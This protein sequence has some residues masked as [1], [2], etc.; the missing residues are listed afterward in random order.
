MSERPLE[1]DADDAATSYQHALLSLHAHA[2]TYGDSKPTDVPGFA[3]RPPQDE[4]AVLAGASTADVSVSA[5]LD[6]LYRLARQ[7]AADDST[8]RQGYEQLAASVLPGRDLEL[9]QLLTDLRTSAQQGT[10]FAETASGGHFSHHETAFLGQQACTVRTVT[11]GGT[12]ATWIYSEIETD[13]DFRDLAAWVDPHKWSSWGPSFFKKMDFVGEPDPAALATPPGDDHWHGVFHEQVQLLRRLNTLL[14]C[15]YWRQSDRAVGMTYDLDLSL[16]GEIDVDRGYL[17]VTALEGGMKRVKALK[18]VGF[19]RPE[20]DALA[21]FVCPVWTDLVRQAVAGAT[22]STVTPPTQGPPSSS[23]LVDTFEAWVDFLGASAGTY[24]R[25]FESTSD[26]VRARSYSSADW[27]DDGRRYWSQL[28]KDW[29]RAWAHGMDTVNEV[30]EHGVD[31]GFTPPG[32]PH[33]VG[34]GAISALTTPATAEPPTAPPA[35]AGAAPG[36]TGAAPAAA[37][38]VPGAAAGAAPGAAPPA[39]TG[40]PPGG[41]GGQE[42]SFVPVPALTP[43]DAPTVSDLVSIEAGGA[44]LAATEITVTVHTEAGATPS[45]RLRTTNTTTPPGLY[46]G[47]LLGPAGVAGTSVQ[48]YVSRATEA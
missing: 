8:T 20:W 46:V 15:A 24:L 45:V 27:L 9:G 13:A 31:A 10:P 48:L 26:K 1:L 35:G 37:G 42:R 17:L 34:R 32:V 5:R 7:G 19:T 14:R 18:V 40:G 4:L 29:A 43:S 16:D 47:T 22:T 3:P 39:A 44:V 30:A 28:A 11:V 6:L 38:P 23:P 12:R 33:E 2:G 21:Q 36:A 41:G 25:L